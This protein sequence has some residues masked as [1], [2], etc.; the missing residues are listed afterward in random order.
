MVRPHRRRAEADRHVADRYVLVDV[1]VATTLLMLGPPG[2]RS[3]RRTQTALASAPEVGA[4]R[5]HRARNLGD[6]GPRVGVRLHR[7]RSVRSAAARRRLTVLVDP[8]DC[9]RY[10]HAML[11]ARRFRSTA[12]SCLA[13]LLGVLTSGL[14]SHSHTGFADHGDAHHVIQADHHAHG[15]QLVEQDVR[16][17][18]T[19]PAI[20]APT[21]SSMPGPGAA[22]ITM[23]PPRTGPIRR[24]RE[25]APPPDAPRAPPVPA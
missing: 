6:T 13:G 2:L 4:W 15:T 23:A 18:T 19:V 5:G 7:P 16:I 9:R 12:A 21:V 20:A 1:A 8:A 3:F 11:F 22:V 24:P 17:Q 25:R 14:P 10:V